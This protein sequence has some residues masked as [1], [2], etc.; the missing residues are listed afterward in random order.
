MT[1]LCLIYARL[2]TSQQYMSSIIVYNLP[3]SKIFT[4]TILFNKHFAKI[5]A[6]VFTE[7]YLGKF[8]LFHPI[9]LVI[10]LP[11][12]DIFSI[13]SLLPLLLFSIINAK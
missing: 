7:E 12:D 4:K 3:D 10:F 9:Y 11:Y 8:S 2:T 13:V 1:I 6:D 5:Y